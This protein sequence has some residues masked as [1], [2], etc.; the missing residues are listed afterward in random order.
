ME[1]VLSVLCW[2]ARAGRVED[3]DGD[4]A[5]V[6]DLEGRFDGPRRLVEDD[7]GEISLSRSSCVFA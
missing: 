1:S 3:D 2:R 5:G 6:E 4:G 7:E